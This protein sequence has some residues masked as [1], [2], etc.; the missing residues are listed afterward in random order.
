MRTLVVVSA[1]V[2]AWA[3][4]A[5]AQELEGPRARQGYWVALGYGAEVEAA[6][7]DGDALTLSGSGGSLRA[8]QMLNPSVG[9]GFRIDL[10][11]GSGDGYDGGGGGLMIEGQW[12]AWRQLGVHAG[13]GLGF[14]SLR[15]PDAEDAVTRGGYGAAALLAVSNDFFLTGRTSG[16]WA[17]TPALTS[18]FFSGGDVDA[19]WITFG[20]QLSWWSGRP[21]NEL[22]L[23]EG[24]AYK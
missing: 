3:G 16:G 24:A 20:L 7:L 6:S 4:V 18:R 12:N 11:T 1:L 13:F 8:G 23:V 2:A 22:D 5:G 9:L 17:I 14:A 21:R 19:L 15:D 10:D